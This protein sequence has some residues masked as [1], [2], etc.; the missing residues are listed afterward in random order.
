MKLYSIIHLQNFYTVP[1]EKSKTVFFASSIM[2]NIVVFPAL[3]KFAVKLICW[4]ALGS[5]SNACS[6]LKSIRSFCN[7][8]VFETRI[9]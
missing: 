8:D 1:Y 3:S 9:I 2:K 6:L 5:A 4:M 7:K